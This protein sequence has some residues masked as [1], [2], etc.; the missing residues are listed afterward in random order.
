MTRNNRTFVPVFIKDLILAL[1][2]LET[3]VRTTGITLR[4]LSEQMG[5]QSTQQ[6]DQRLRKGLNGLIA[7]QV[8]PGL[9]Y[10]ADEERVRVIGG[11]R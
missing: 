2:A 6:D 3:Q 1:D 5:L 11:G 7:Q 9:S 10:S 4:E 8:V